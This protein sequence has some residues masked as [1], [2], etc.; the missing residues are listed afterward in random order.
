MLRR[1]AQRVAAAGAQP[2]QRDILMILQCLVC[3]Q[4]TH[5]L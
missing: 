2:H 4:Q 1:P 5:S 3:Y